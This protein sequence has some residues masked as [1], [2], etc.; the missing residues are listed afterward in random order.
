[1][2]AS[3]TGKT[4]LFLTRTLAGEEKESVIECSRG[5]GNGL[6]APTP[7]SDPVPPETTRPSPA[8]TLSFESNTRPEGNR[9]KCP[10]RF[11][12]KGSRANRRS[13]LIVLGPPRVGSFNFVFQRSG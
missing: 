9:H 4:S 7:K 13:G 6:T 11:L 5:L 2:S 12:P 10:F 8:A 1:M 3:H